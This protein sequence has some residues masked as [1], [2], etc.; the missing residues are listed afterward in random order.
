LVLSRLGLRR[1][2]AA[3]DKEALARELLL[4]L[5]PEMVARRD[6]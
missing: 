5:T 3:Q 4:T 1:E 2:F 6:T